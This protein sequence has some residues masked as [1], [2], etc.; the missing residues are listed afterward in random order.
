[1]RRHM[2]SRSQVESSFRAWI[3][4][5]VWSQE[6]RRAIAAMGEQYAREL[7]GLLR[8]ADNFHADDQRSEIASALRGE[9]DGSRF[10]PIIQSAAQ[11]MEQWVD[12]STVRRS[13][14]LW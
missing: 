3:D 2:P 14:Y 10:E 8:F 7:D 12:S 4:E 11:T 1:M 13:R 9:R 6:V 5:R